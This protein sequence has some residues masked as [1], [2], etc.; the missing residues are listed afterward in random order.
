MP[1]E[2]ESFWDANNFAVITDKTK[3]AMEMTIQEL[4][5]MGKNVYTVDMS[6]KPEKGT[7]HNVSDL[8]EDIERA[9]IGV[10]TRSPADV[11]DALEKKGINSHWIHWRT[12]TPDVKERCR[13][14]H[15][16]CITGRC[17]MMYLGKGLSIHTMHRCIAKL[18]G[19][20]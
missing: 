8:P 19:K 3:P 2:Q 12:E 17:P 1:T 4:A 15:L 13:K 6:N 7:L 5:K 18:M 10:T 11:M 14:P 9:I 20:Y 16:Q